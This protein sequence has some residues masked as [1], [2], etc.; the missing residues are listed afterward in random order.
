MN[1][2]DED[3]MVNR[4]DMLVGSRIE[5]LSQMPAQYTIGFIDGIKESLEAIK[6]HLGFDEPSQEL[7]DLFLDYCIKKITKQVFNND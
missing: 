3:K 4:F 6:M 7:L 5:G 2:E 1:K